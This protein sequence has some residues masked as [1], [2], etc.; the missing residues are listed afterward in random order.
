M[1]RVGAKVM[2]VEVVI[3]DVKGAVET[4]LAPEKAATVVEGDGAADV[5]FGFKTLK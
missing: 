5:L 1:S 4:L 3:P 2:V